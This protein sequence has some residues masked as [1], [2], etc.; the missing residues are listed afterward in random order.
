MRRRQKTKMVRVRIKDLEKMK[1]MARQAQ[2]KLPDF[3]AELIKAYK[4]RKK[5]EK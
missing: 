3:Q 5:N 1:E 4:K 2:K